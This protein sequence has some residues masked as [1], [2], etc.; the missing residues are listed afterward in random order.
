MKLYVC[1]GT[2]RPDRHPCGKAH[3]ALSDAGHEPEV[4][5][6]H[7]CY[8]TDP[9]FPGRREVRRLSGNYQVPTLVLDDGSVIDGSEN[10]VAWANTNPSGNP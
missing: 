5:K 1:W 8:R 9:L 4:V 6:T 3:R 10:V 2:F 7:G